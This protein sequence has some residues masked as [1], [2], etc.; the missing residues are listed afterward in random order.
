MAGALPLYTC[1]W[2][3]CDCR[4]RL[5]YY[6]DRMLGL[7]TGDELRIEISLTIDEILNSSQC[8]DKLAVLWEGDAINRK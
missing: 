8:N 7:D 4:D 1:K 3:A 6:A 2:K 5:L